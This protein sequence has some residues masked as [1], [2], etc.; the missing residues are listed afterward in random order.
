MKQA[1][2]PRFAAFLQDDNMK[3]AVDDR[4]WFREPTAGRLDGSSA[5]GAVL[6]AQQVDPLDPLIPGVSELFL[7]FARSTYLVTL[8][9]A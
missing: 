1:T 4:V 3:T 2:R 5:P 7:F 6:G 9:S 8:N